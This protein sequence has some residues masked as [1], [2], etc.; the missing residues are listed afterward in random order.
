MRASSG[1]TSAR[2]AKSSQC[3][4]DARCSRHRDQVD[5]VIG[6]AAGRVQADDAVDDRA[7]VDHAADRRVSLPSAVI[8]K[9]TLDGL[10]R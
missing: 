8:V 3:E 2:S 7:L 10:A 9:R 1:V 6:R 5:G 4:H